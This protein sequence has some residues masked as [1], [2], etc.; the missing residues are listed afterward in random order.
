MTTAAIALEKEGASATTRTA[1][2][3]VIST[4][5]LA[6]LSYYAFVRPLDGDEGF[7]TTAARLVW[8]GKTPYKDFF[9][10]QAPL[11][12]YLYSWVCG[13]H[14]HSLIAM[15][16]LSAACT[17]LATLLWGAWALSLS[18]RIGT[19]T[20]F[21]AFA[22]VLLNPYWASWGVV[23]KTYA[24]A[25]F[26]MT[27]ASLFLYVALTSG[28]IR[29][30]FA[31]GAVLG[32]CASAR[33]FYAPLIPAALIWMI[34]N[35]R[36]LAQNGR[37]LRLFASGALCGLAPM[38]LSFVRGPQ[39]FLFNNLEYHRLDLG[40]LEL[41]DGKI[42]HGYQSLGH[43][44]LVYTAMIFVRLIGMHPYFTIE[45]VLAV[46]GW[47]SLRKVRSQTEPYTPGQ[48]LYF[49]VAFVLLAAYV[50]TVLCHFPPYDQY[51]DTPIVPLL[52]PFVA[53][54]LRVT[55]ASAR[56]HA[57][58]LALAVAAPLLMAAEIG[59]DPW[60]EGPPA[61]WHLPVYREVS[62]SI[63][64][65]SRPNEVVLSFW[66]GFL[67]ES[68]RSYFPGMED[69]FALRIMNH[70]TRPQ[71][72]LYRL[73]SNQRI[74]QAITSREFNLLVIHPWIFEYFETLTPDEVEAFHAAVEAN[75]VRIE[76]ISGVCIY[77]SRSIK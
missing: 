52:V 67:F 17:G 5:Y 29:W 23:V 48:R 2:V 25:N 7:Y 68:Q 45:L 53:E 30:Y 32:F 22:T 37:S 33:L 75:Y 70:L 11:L 10:Q 40:Y 59:R 60:L 65:N 12:P 35:R 19:K 41:A 14:P 58:A 73:T 76:E 44:V 77:R 38:I 57:L 15:R 3:A 6:G 18:G 46:A 34:L 24:M 27:L 55:F 66:P 16:L 74:M 1:I 13:V 72:E 28:R 42:L 21:A 51:F 50:L 61:M 31:A 63:S 71:R 56:R 69:Q 43:V 39:V 4:V 20:A 64:A 9:Y 47:L 26:L 36:S 62:K 54:G 8:E 49:S